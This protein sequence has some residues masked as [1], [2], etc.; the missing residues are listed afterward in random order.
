M[1]AAAHVQAATLRTGGASLT[2]RHLGVEYGDKAVLR[3]LTLDIAPG[4]RVA[5]VGA[6]GGGKTTLLRALAGLTPYSTPRCRRVREAPP[7]R[8]VAACTC[9]AAV[10]RAPA[11]AAT[12][13][14]GRA[15]ARRPP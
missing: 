10:M 5:L 8:R 12:C 6:S 13:V 4:E 2:L 14:P 3:D 15:R 11:R 9:A 7:V 1:T